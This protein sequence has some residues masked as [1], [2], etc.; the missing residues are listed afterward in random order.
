MDE[1]TLFAEI[2]SGVTTKVLCKILSKIYRQIKY[3]TIKYKEESRNKKIKR[4]HSTSIIRPKIQH[5][6]KRKISYVHINEPSAGHNFKNI[7][8]KS[9]IFKND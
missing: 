9:V 3:T 7:R 5:D 4:R 1:T 8:K 6:R 2:I